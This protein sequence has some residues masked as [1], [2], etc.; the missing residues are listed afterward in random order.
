MVLAP[1]YGQPSHPLPRKAIARGI[2]HQLA[3]ELHPPR[4]RVFR[5]TD[6]PQCSTPLATRDKTFIYAS[7]AMQIK[8]L[9]KNLADAVE[10]NSTEEYRVWKVDPEDKDGSEFPSGAII[11]N[12][13]DEAEIHFEILKSSDRLL[14]D[15]LIQNEEAFAVEFVKNGKWL[16]SPPTNR[17]SAAEN[18]VLSHVPLPLFSQETSFFNRMGQ[19]S[20]S[21]T[22]STPSFASTMLSGVLTAQ[23]MSVPSTLVKPVSTVAFPLNRRKQQSREPG[24]LGLGNM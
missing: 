21:E 15:E 5:V 8:Y 9:L 2:H 20:T 10:P 12:L 19:S 4:L 24:T 7:S 14:E 22:A 1:R 3:L 16:I 23:G 18:A 6:D 13:R 17:P 11:Q